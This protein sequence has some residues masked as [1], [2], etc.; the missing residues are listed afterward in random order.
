MTKNNIIAVVI[1]FSVLLFVFIYRI[2]FSNNMSASL[3]VIV[4]DAGFIP[5]HIVVSKNSRVTWVN[6]GTLPHWPASDF[7]PTHGIYPEFDP[8][9]E[10]DPN[11]EWSFEFDKVGNWHFHD[12][13]NPSVRGVVEVK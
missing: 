2:Y 8:K 3:T 5:E 13:L 6:K 11:G 1:F 4:N 12:H 9:R 10:I 7:H